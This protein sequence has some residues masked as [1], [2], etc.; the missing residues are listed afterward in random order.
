MS[1]RWLELARRITAAERE[2]RQRAEEL[3]N[4]ADVMAAAR[5][6]WTA[7]G[8]QRARDIHLE[9]AA[10]SRAPS[11]EPEPLDAAL[12]SIWLHGKW[13]WLTSKMTTEQREAAADSVARYD[14]WLSR[15]DDD[16]NRIDDQ[17][18]RWWR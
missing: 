3:W 18:L 2:H 7:D 5:E 4:H 17:E 10:E 11:G 1:D 13:R 8:L 9:V 6:R 14:E 16:L 15:Q 12:F